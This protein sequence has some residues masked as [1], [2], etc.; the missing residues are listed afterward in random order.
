MELE[1]ETSKNFITGKVEDKILID[2]GPGYRE[3]LIK[4]PDGTV[5]RV[6][7]YLNADGSVKSK[8]VIS[9]DTEVAD[10][11]DKQ[12]RKE[13]IFI[14][15]DGKVKKIIQILNKD[16]EVVMEE[17]IELESI[18][19][20]QKAKSGIINNIKKYLGD[21]KEITERSTQKAPKSLFKST[22]SNQKERHIAE[23]GRAHV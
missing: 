3:Y 8:E 1:T 11:S 12:T 15:E 21:G 6:R 16:G 9:M 19:E 5:E 4:H 18:D 2:E 14:D 7:E 17:I 23:I 22:P 10:L 20:Q 13:K